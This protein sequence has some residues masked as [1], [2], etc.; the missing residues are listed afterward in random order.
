MTTQCNRVGILFM[1]TRTAFGLLGLLV[2]NLIGLTAQSVV[3][4]VV[5]VL[6]AFGGGSILAFMKE[7]PLEFRKEAV[8]AI[9]ALSLMC[10]VGVYTGIIVCE[11]RILSPSGVRYGVGAE[12]NETERQ[13]A[14]PSVVSD[15]KYLRENLLSEVKAIEQQILHGLSYTNAYQRLAERIYHYQ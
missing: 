3:T 12:K 14:L 11:H 9:A 13:V 10:L 5:P 4:A 2:G 8:Q 7:L 6:F 15:N 1:K